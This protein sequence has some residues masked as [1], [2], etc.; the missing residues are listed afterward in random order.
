ML[1]ALASVTLAAGLAACSSADEEAMVAHARRV[2]D[3]RVTGDDN[4]RVIANKA[5]RQ[6]DCPLQNVEV[7]FVTGQSNAAGSAEPPANAAAGQVYLRFGGTCWT[8]TLPLL[9]ASSLPSGANNYNPFLAVAN[10]YAAATGKQV[11]LHFLSVGGASIT[12]WTSDLADELETELRQA[13]PVDRVLWQQGESDALRGM[14]TA[15]YLQHFAAVVRTVHS[16]VGL[17]AKLHVAK[18][19]R[20]YD[21]GGDNPVGAAH[22]ALQQQ[23]LGGPDTDSLG[24]AYRY[25]RCHFNAAGVEEFARLWTQALL[26]E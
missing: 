14:D 18:S 11:V 6:V 15:T 1:R 17:G 24:A 3:Q 26:Q 19:S 13:A 23:G 7:W 10:S 12:R 21:L 8:A 20:C 9:G 5:A 25:D 16:A 22:L 4:A 2:L